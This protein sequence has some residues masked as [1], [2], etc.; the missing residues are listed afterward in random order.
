[1]Q[2]PYAL[3]ALPEVLKTKWDDE[4][5][6]P[7]RDQFPDDAKSSPE[8]LQAHVEDLT[9]RDVKI[10]Y[11]KNLQGYLW[12]HGYE[13]GEYATPLFADVAPKLKQWKD[14][15]YDLAIYSSGSVFAQKLLFGHVK[16]GTAGAGTKR[17]RADVANGEEETAGPPSKKRTATSKTEQ[18][19]GSAVDDSEAREDKPSSDKKAKGSEDET[20]IDDLQYLIT[21]WY[22]TTNAGPKTD[23]NSYTKIADAM[24]VSKLRYQRDRFANC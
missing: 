23:A 11:H 14:D 12:E 13:T 7:Y 4:D 18:K 15:G 17:R 3:K 6:K 22:D 20:D 1:V 5:F 10:A 21:D 16:S 19:E 9:K 2:F 8:A 24:E